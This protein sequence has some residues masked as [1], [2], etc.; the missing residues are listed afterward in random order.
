LIV[1]A[2]A[3][4]AALTVPLGSVVAEDWP[5][6]HHDLALSG[7][8]PDSAP[9]TNQ[10]LWTF[11][12]NASVY[13]SAAVVGNSV[14]VGSLDG[15]LYSLDKYTGGLN[16]AFDSGA[17]IHSSPAVAYGKVYFLSENGNVYALDAATG[18]PAWTTDIG[19]G[20][21][22]WSSPAVHAGT[23]F[24]G[25][26]TGWIRA[27]DA[28][29]GM[30]AW[31]TNIGGS[32]N[33]PITVVN[34]LVYSGTHNFNNAAPTLA[35]LNEASGTMAWTY[36]YHL[37]HGGAT[38][39]VNC[40]GAAVVDGD[41]DG[42]PEVHIGLYNWNGATDQAV[43]LNEFNGV[44]IWSRTINGNSTSTPAVHAGTVFVG[45]D[46]HNVYALDA[47]NNGSVIW[48]FPTGGQ[49]WSSPAVSGDGKVCF[50]SLDHTV[51]CVEEATG[52]PIWSYFTGAS[53]LYA[54]PAIS[55]GLL[56]IGS[57]NGKVYA[58]G[59][60]C[61][62]PDPL[63]QGY[64]HRQCLGVPASDGGI[65]PGRNGRGPG[66][67]TEPGF[68][69][70]LMPCAFERLV[71]LGFNDVSTCDGMDADP[72]SDPCE[73]ALKQ[74]T[75]VTLNVC[76]ERL[77]NGCEVDLSPWGCEATSVGAAIEEIAGLIHGDE[78]NKAKSCAAAINEAEALADGG[79]ASTGGECSAPA[80][81]R[82]EREGLW[83][84]TH[85]DVRGR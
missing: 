44:E 4:V 41:G 43:C 1:G 75:A 30:I 68:V 42:F 59:I 79:S 31:S 60:P 83:G 73:K 32:P 16:W 25:S 82:L 28:M 77:S 23:V 22:D 64:W 17:Q 78:C 72:P 46:D 11:Q 9:D 3:L 5:M 33:S 10:L 8:T 39:M 76:S 20:P 52:N 47:T 18:M 81:R 55:E 54:S 12:T 66:S 37:Y 69:E 62:D 7:Y 49:V 67:P 36:D 21:W 27:L 58:F 48:N 14:F 70:E 53:H 2:V 38:G 56:F 19:S 65:D 15:Y 80:A 51:Y 45:S 6:F 50:G 61:L 71:D 84:T 29:T 35:A 57:Q 85:R 24:I 74:L 13:S 34:G 40:N 63:T 26:S